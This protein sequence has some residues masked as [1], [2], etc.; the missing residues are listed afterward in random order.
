MK[1]HYFE[2]ET[3]PNDDHLLAMAKQQGYVPPSCLLGGETVMGLV[4]S[5]F[6][7]CNGCSCERYKCG[8]RVHNK[9]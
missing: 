8:G 4:N 6:D 1:T 2:E 7:P 9:T 3:T 5:G